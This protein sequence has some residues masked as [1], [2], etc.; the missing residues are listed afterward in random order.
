MLTTLEKVIALKKSSIFSTLPNEI[1]AAVAPLLEESW[2]ENG[3]TVFKKGELGDCMYIIVQGKVRVHDDDLTLNFLEDGKVFGEMAA[4]DSEPRVASVT[5]VAD[6]C[7]LRLA[8]EPLYELID[9]QPDLA[10][11]IIRTL[12][13]HLRARIQDMNALLAGIATQK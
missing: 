10:R 3:T 11:G 13:G 4:L 9:E 6:T 8:Q 2:F 1:L 7:L 12:S 5:A